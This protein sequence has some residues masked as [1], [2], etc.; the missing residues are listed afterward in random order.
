M[1]VAFYFEHGEIPEI[2]TGHK[3]RAKVISEELKKRGHEIIEG[4][5][6]VLIVDHLFEQTE[7]IKEVKA[8]GIK[9]VLIDGIEAD[10][11][12]V[13][14]SISAFYNKSAQYRG[15]NY[16]AFPSHPDTYYK[17]NKSKKIFVSM[18]GFDAN[19][20]TEMAIKAVKNL[21]Y[22]ALVTRSINSTIEPCD[23]VEIFE[24]TNY[25]EAMEQCVAGVTAGGLTMFQALHFGLP[26][27]CVPQYE[28]QLEN[29]EQ[30]K[31]WCVKTESSEGHIGIYLDSLIQDTKFRNKLSKSA[32]QA[33][34]GNGVIRICDLIEEL[35]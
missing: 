18:G 33:I 10:A 11:A 29:I 5:P 16:M 24:G 34:D 30:V 23:G 12:L 8:K 25:F 26:C 17:A 28:H 35:Q 22:T 1:K 15:L 9:V 19:N 13:D 14:L 7:R 4:Y 3:Y 20:L 31:Q 27:V 21:R 6:D 32:K 2:G